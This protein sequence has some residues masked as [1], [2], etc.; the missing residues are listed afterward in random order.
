MS[1]RNGSTLFF[2]L[3]VLAQ[4]VFAQVPNT[5]DFWVLTNPEAPFVVQDD[6]RQLR[7]MLVDVVNGVLSEANIKQQILAAPWERV[8]REARVKSNVLVFALAR[9]P[10]RENY[11]HWITP[12]TANVF[13]VYGHSAT[14]DHYQHLDELKN[15]SS[16]AVLN[17]DVRHKIL[18][19]AK[20]TNIRPYESWQEAVDSVVNGQSEAIFLS[21]AGMQFFCEKSTNNCKELKRVFMYERMFSYLV[22]SKAETDEQLADRLKSAALRF[23]HS[24]EFTQLTRHW[25]KQYEELPIPMHMEDGVLNLWQQ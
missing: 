11:Y 19:N 5:P 18:L 16:I 10:E 20:M 12:L 1:F 13:A 22:L 23:K 2:I 24:E 8:E 9:T 3:V 17:N 15:I 7:G 25:L 4:R 14:K 21:D 6:K